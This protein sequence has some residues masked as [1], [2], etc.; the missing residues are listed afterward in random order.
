MGEIARH[1]EDH[2]G[3]R[4]G[5][6]HGS[7]A[8]SSGVAKLI[9]KGAKSPPAVRSGKSRSAMNS[10]ACPDKQPHAGSDIGIGGEGVRGCCSPGI[11]MTNETP[12][13]REAAARFAFFTNDRLS[14][15]GPVLSLL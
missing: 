7:G 11:G 6:G 1:A 4:T 15:H 3:I 2:E 12:T 8:F 9:T 13:I 5:G 14:G 10:L